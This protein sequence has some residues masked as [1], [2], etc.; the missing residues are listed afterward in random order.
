MFISF[1][2][3]LYIVIF[4][5]SNILLFSLFF[6]I[7]FSSSHFN[8]LAHIVNFFSCVAFASCN[9]MMCHFEAIVMYC[10]CSVSV[11]S[12]FRNSFLVLMFQLVSVD[13]VHYK[14]FF[15]VYP[16]AHLFSCEIPVRDWG[17]LLHACEQEVANWI[18][19]GWCLLEFQSLRPCSF[20][21]KAMAEST[22]RWFVVKEKHCLLAE[23][24]W[25]IR[26]ANMTFIV[27]C[28]CKFWMNFFPFIYH[29]PVW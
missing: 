10:Q 18:R 17:L 14:L 21:W 25:L 8:I 26:Q 23:K 3:L 5:L 15:T 19:S 11:V 29:I 6:L 1:S 27:L 4:I 12:F 22:V 16:E 20:G 13:W 9:S 7:Y 24:V 2:F 28:H